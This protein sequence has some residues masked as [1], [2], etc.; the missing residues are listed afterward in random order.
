MNMIKS[1]SNDGGISYKTVYIPSTGIIRI[2][3]VVGIIDRSSS[4]P[5]KRPFGKRS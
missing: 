3:G 1:F 2:A 5:M 4:V